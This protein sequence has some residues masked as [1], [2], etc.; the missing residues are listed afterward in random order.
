M[1]TRPTV[2]HRERAC[3]TSE[4]IGQIDGSVLLLYAGVLPGDLLNAVWNRK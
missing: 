4:R 1:S 2:T 3:E